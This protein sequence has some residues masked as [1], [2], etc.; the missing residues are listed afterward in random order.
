MRV[1]IATAGRF[2]LLDLARELDRLGVAV[3]FYSYVPWRRAKS[4]GL[5]RRCH[6]GMV[7]A[8]FPLVAIERLFPWILPNLIERL[9]CYAIDIV[10]ILRMRPCDV[11]ICMSG[12]YVWA[13]RY[14]KWRFGASVHIHRS[15][16]H[17]LLQ[18]AILS[19]LPKARQ[20]SDFMVARELAGYALADRIVIPSAHVAQSFAR[21]P[22]CTAKLFLNPLGVDLEQFPLRQ[23][24]PHD[25]TPTILFVGQWSF[26]KGVDVLESAL[27]DIRNVRIAHVGSLTD[28]PFPDDPRFIHHVHV[29]QARLSEFYRAASIFVLPSRQDG[30][31]LVLSQAL[32]SGLRVVCTDRTGGPDLARLGSIGRLIEVVPADDPAAL[33]K[34]IERG[35]D[36][37]RNQ[38]ILPIQPDEREMLGWKS[39]AIR[40]L[41]FMEQMQPSAVTKCN[42]EDGALT[43]RLDTKR[44]RLGRRI[45]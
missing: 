7:A 39:Y 1:G 19:A 44:Q 42:R 31:G 21:W 25:K 12:L 13:P 4:F 6:I 45:N 11:F 8:L 35:L 22:E 34:A 5:P 17:I 9:T 33:R 30:F 26:Q 16:Q 20:V 15:S 41:R 24:S 27:R 18:K 23:C 14:A 10:V 36:E 38:S 43:R 28:A 29:P 37:N 32:V 2:H 3:R 40:T